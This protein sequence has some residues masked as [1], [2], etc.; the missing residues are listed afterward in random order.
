MPWEAAVVLGDGGGGVRRGVSGVLVGR[1]G[2]D[3]CGSE[4][5]IGSE[6]VAGE[7][8]GR[9]RDDFG[10]DEGRDRGLQEGLVDDD[11]ALSRYS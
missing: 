8:V 10:D 7:V 2:G 4:D 6:L 3:G 1:S 5:R 11:D 9:R